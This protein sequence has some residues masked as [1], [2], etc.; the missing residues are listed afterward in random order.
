LAFI[1]RAATMNASF[2]RMNSPDERFSYDS[3]ASE[4]AARVESAPF[5]A[6]Y[7]RPA[8]LSLLPAVSGK[9]ILDAGCGSGWYSVELVARGATVDAIDAS[10]AMVAYARKRLSELPDSQG[11]RVTVAV[12]DLEKPLPFDDGYFAGA[13]SPLVLH[14]LEDWRPALRELHRVVEQGGWLQ[15]STHHPA[16]DAALFKTRNYFSVERVTDHW[17]WV[18]DVTFYR[19][20]LTEI[21]ESLK[22]CGFGVERVAEPVPTE[23]FLA[24]DPDA[25]ERLLNQPAFLIVVA[26][27]R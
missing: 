18:G 5:N 8:M 25:Y 15:L 20:S 27:A 21:F 12:S 24:A 14:Y 13:I 4:Y 16:A 11:R 9:R 17:D 23:G 10:A 7:E 26:T 19:R 6:F 22:D 3:I 1:L 2:Q